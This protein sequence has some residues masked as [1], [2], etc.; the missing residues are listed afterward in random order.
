VADYERGGPANITRPYWLTD[1]AISASSW[2]YTVGIEYYSSI[3]MIHSLLDRVS[4]N[5]N[6]LLNISPTSAG[7][8]PD[9][10]QRV[11]LDIGAYLGRYGEAVYGT[12]AWD[13]YGEGPNKAGGGS[14]TEPLTGN[15]SDIRFTRNKEKTVLYATI[16]GW[17]ESSTVSI[18]S[19]GSDA[20]VDLANLKSIKLLGDSASDFID[21]PG[22]TQDPNALTIQLPSEPAESQAYVL[23]LSFKRNIPVPQIA[24]GASAF[25]ARNVH[26][27]GISLPQGH[28]SSVFLNDAGTK[29]EDIRLLRVDD[30]ATVTI[31]ANGDLTGDSTSFAAG[32]HAVA[33]GSVGSLSVSQRPDRG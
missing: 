4:K 33:L 23:K 21:V 18:A 25:T 5:G 11:L 2:S 16:L 17:P 3:Q 1:D 30:G 13:I 32:E 29:P 27:R 10:Q 14:F 12:R 24:A 20:Q 28:F 8:L 6:M 19:L 22:W 15:S 31:Y 26:G 9:E 7:I